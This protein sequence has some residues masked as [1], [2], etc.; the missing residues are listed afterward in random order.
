MSR[1]G[2]KMYLLFDK[3][4]GDVCTTKT[5]KSSLHVAFAYSKDEAVSHSARKRRGQLQDQTL[6]FVNPSRRMVAGMR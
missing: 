6:G 5:L 4:V 2:E 3:P 1:I